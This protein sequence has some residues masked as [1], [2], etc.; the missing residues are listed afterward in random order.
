MRKNVT[1]VVEIVVEWIGI[2]VYIAFLFWGAISC[3]DSIQRRSPALTDDQ[4]V[5]AWIEFIGILCI[6]GL[7]YLA[8][9]IVKFYLSTGKLPKDALEIAIFRATNKETLMF[10][11][12]EKDYASKFFPKKG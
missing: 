5:L 3:K 11:L 12:A 4:Y 2:C 1:K 9:I 6:A 8:V 7:I 10:L